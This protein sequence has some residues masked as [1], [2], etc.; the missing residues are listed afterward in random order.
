V[1]TLSSHLAM[2]IAGLVAAVLSIIGGLFAL[3]VILRFARRAGW[4]LLAAFGFA[5]L[6]VGPPLLTANRPPDPRLPSLFF[7]HYATSLVGFGLA[8]FAAIASLIRLLRRPRPGPMPDAPT[9][10]AAGHFPDLEAA[11]AEIRRRLEQVEI[12]LAGQNVYLLLAPDEEAAAGL[13]GAAG[14]RLFA[15]APE[16]PAPVHAYATAD[17][18]L[19]DCAGAS[20]LGSQDAAGV[21][22]LEALCRLLLAER[23][24]CPIVRGV[25]VVFPND[26]AAQADAPRRAGAVR[27]DL[28]AIGRVLKVRC[29]TYA[30]FTQ[31]E[32]VPGVPEFLARMTAPMLAQRAGFAV[33]TTQE[34]SGD[35]VDRGLVWMSGWFRSWILN[36]ISADPLDDRGN[37]QLARLDHEIRRRRKRYRGQ[38]ESA[39]AT[40][41]DREPVL[42][43]GCYFVATGAGPDAQAFAAG[44]LR[45]PRAR[46]IA[47]HVST[48]WGLAAEADDRRYRRLAAVVAIGGGLILVPAW[49][50][51]ASLSLLWLIGLLAL[52]VAW[53][54]VFLR[55]PGRR[56]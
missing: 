23:P 41:R 44:L 45:G 40:P 10:E 24:D 13:V 56:P 12:D 48:R 28:Q 32:A 19:L 42:F 55:L 33:P 17:G 30:I 31:M 52:A 39:F 35:L 6:V 22:R 26:W 37:G 51:M 3:P 14:L 5:L 47:D 53:V 36:L 11:W 9:A 4:W 29:P 16:G 43:R 34:F 50:W 54:V 27:D 2:W 46:L 15:E 49:L 25:A 7:D 1:S 8:S 20:S 21:A 18:V 38:L